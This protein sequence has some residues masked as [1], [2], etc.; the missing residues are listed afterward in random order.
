MVQGKRDWR[1]GSSIPCHKLLQY[2]QLR[3]RSVGMLLKV[4]VDLTLPGSL[5]ASAGVGT[6]VKCHY[7]QVHSGDRAVARSIAVTMISELATWAWACHCWSCNPLGFYN[8]LSEFW[9]PYKDIAFCGLIIT[10]L[11]IYE[12]GTFH[13]PSCCC[14]GYVIVQTAFLLYSKPPPF[15]ISLGFGT[16]FG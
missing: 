16:C 5:V 4:W 11:G 10:V 3:P 9:S 7:S 8:I 2:S 13:L 14:P 6:K 15:S 1:Y 12:H